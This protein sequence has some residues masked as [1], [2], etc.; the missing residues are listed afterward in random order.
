[1]TDLS[2]LRQFLSSWFVDSEGPGGDEAA[3]RQFAAVSD[4]AGVRAVLN[5]AVALAS[6][7]DEPL[8]AMIDTE[9]NRCFEGSE[10][11]RAW[12]GRMCE[13]IR[14]ESAD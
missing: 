14:Q 13:A 4:R 12:L 8:L 2:A 9:A 6:G 5:E 7:P 10:E 11:A 3:A 1:M